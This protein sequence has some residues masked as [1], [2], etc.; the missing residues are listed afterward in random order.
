MPNP[1]VYL[2]TGATPNTDVILYESVADSTGG[3]HTRLVTDALALSDLATA[4]AGE[5]E[6]G[7]VSDAAA[8]GDIAEQA[9]NYLR[10]GRR[11]VTFSGSSS[12]PGQMGALMGMF[13]TEPEVSDPEPT[14]VLVSRRLV[15]S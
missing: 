3:A 4:L 6:T 5:A 13:S 15:F 9:A 11:V 12:D 1:D 14:N 7:S 2:R 8:I 10:Q